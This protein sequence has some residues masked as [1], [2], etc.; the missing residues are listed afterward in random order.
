MLSMEHFMSKHKIKWITL[1]SLV[2]LFALVFGFALHTVIPSRKAHAV[3]Y[4]TTAI[5]SEGTGADVGSISVK[6]GEST[7]NYIGFTFRDGGS[8]YFRR[9]LALKWFEAEKTE[10]PEEDDSGADT[11]SLGGRALALP[12][13][14]RYLGM[15]F[16]FQSLEFD[17]FSIAF[18]SAEENITKEGKATNSLLFKVEDGALKLAV[19][20]AA[21]QKLEGE[22]LDALYT[23]TVI[24]DVEKD[25][26]DKDLTVAFVGE[27][28]VGEFLLEIKYG[29]TVLDLGEN[30]RF[31]N[32]G[33]NYMEYR[34]QTSTTPNTPITFKADVPGATTTETAVH[35][36]AMK[37]LNGQTFELND[38]GLVEDNAPPALVINEK[39]YAYTLGQRFSLNSEAIDVCRDSVNVSR[40]YYMAKHAKNGEGETASDSIYKKP[41]T[42]DE[43]DYKNLSTTSTFFMPTSDTGA[44]ETEYVSI[45]FRLN[46]SRTD[47]TGKTIEYY[48]YLTWYAAD[49]SV[50]KTLP[51]VDE[52]AEEEDRTV[53]YLDFIKVNREKGGPAF[54]GVTADPD[55]EGADRENKVDKETYE[56]AVNAYAEAVDAAARELS[57]GQGA[58]FYLPS[59]RGLISSK[60]ADYRNLRFSIYYYKPG[61]GEGGSV[62]TE[63][64]L[65]YNSLR[66][67]IQ[68]E[69]WYRFRVIAADASNN[70]MEMYHDGKL[71]K[72]TGDNVWEIDEIPEFSFYVK[73][74]G[75]TIEKQ[76]VQRTGYLDSKYEFVKFDIIATPGY[77][78]EYTLYRLDPSKLPAGET[79]PDYDDCWK[80]AEEYFERFYQNGEGSLVEI[81]K[82]NSDITEDNDKWADTDNDYD[83][84]PDSGLSFRPQEATYYFLQVVVW[85]ADVGGYS[86][87]GYQVIRVDNPIDR[88]VA[89]SNWFEQNVVSVVLFSISAVLAIA[90]IVLFVVKPA[91]KKIEEVD[92]DKLK[93]KKKK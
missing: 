1:I 10:E 72:V 7:V 64:S 5:F 58:Y 79:L 61:V 54:T 6:E 26:T 12:A 32:I 14:A 47:S 8:V 81:S 93:G 21:N 24:A 31:T 3:T 70:A 56:A 85:D 89:R 62:S 91:D 74:T 92:L 16:S 43:G 20:N 65:R 51:V 18:E 76:T 34:S 82:Y 40:S 38:S 90:I 69:G 39:V 36:I 11:Q 78:T 73:Y 80:N 30:D 29:D 53:E 37:E 19:V 49:D 28:E 66:F 45:R 75:A 50:V 35:L 41:T 15:R 63:T 87:T 27:G 59:L 83:W 9:N 46:D 67:E 48:V 68:Q 22:E 13:V 17:G 25:A 55:A 77:E 60:Y 42:S 88:V 2:A 33:G 71:E 4:S 23:V 57:A 86:T 52:D 84:D 44:D